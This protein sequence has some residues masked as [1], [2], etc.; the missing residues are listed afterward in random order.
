MKRFFY[1]CLVSCL[2]IQWTTAQSGRQFGSASKGIVYEKEF[3]MDIRLHTNGF[4][5]GANFG[6]LKTYYKTTYYHIGLGEIK[7]P[8]EFRQSFDLTLPGSPITSRSFIYG[9]QNNLY[10]LRGGYGV[11]KY[12]SEKARKKGVAVGMSYEFGPSI[13][14]L[15]PYYLQIIRD[16]TG[17]NF[18]AVVESEKFTEETAEAFLAERSI[19]GSSG[20]TEGISEISIIPGGQAK[21]AVHFDWGAYDEFVKGIEAGLMVDVYF[22]RVPIMVDDVSIQNIVQGGAPVTIEPRNVQNRPFFINF[23]LNF[24]FGKRW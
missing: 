19:F 5:L 16:E 21:V 22:Q 4:A 9:K 2:F 3:N 20:F 6:K 10:V 1:I 17:D 15:K 23:F 14:L 12:F 24:Q 13:G 11:K 18:T 8:K 7:H